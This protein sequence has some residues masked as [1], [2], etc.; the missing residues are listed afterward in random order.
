MPTG[1]FTA[2]EVNVTIEGKL[3][4]W[5]G[6]GRKPKWL[7]EYEAANGLVRGTKKADAAA[8]ADAKVADA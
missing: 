6:R 5:C 2:R 3:H 8:P 1:Q 4:S 7:S